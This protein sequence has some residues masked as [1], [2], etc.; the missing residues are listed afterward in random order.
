[1]AIACVL[2]LS[3]DVNNVADTTTGDRLCDDETRGSVG[4]SNNVRRAE[5]RR[6]RIENVIFLAVYCC[7]QLA[8][9]ILRFG[10]VVGTTVNFEN[11]R[12]SL[13]FSQ[14]PCAHRCV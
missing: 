5:K 2:L 14:G 1:M 7:Q 10:V 9:D 3:Q 4:S 12:C 6:R 11:Y 8:I 13:P